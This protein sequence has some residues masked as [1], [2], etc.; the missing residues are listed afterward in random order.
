MMIKGGKSN[1]YELKFHQSKV[2]CTRIFHHGSRV[3]NSFI[4]LYEC[5][6][7]S[8]ARKGEALKSVSV[9]FQA[10][11]AITDTPAWDFQSGKI[12]L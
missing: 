2:K 4:L 11:L 3:Y 12:K 5:L 7:C 6:K 1:Q 8:F 10:F 9:A